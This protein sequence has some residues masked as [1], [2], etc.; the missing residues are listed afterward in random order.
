MSAR[1]TLTQRW[2]SN[3]G[4]AGAGPATFVIFRCAR[5]RD[6]T[7]INTKDCANPALKIVR[8]KNP[9]RPALGKDKAMGAEARRLW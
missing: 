3:T 4:H 9:R 7:L 8:I 5:T 2:A 1:T 6:T